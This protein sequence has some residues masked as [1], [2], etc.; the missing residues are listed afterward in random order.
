M[1]YVQRLIKLV[2][3][4]IAVPAPYFSTLVPGSRFQLSDLAAA[5]TTVEKNGDSKSDMLR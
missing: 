3:S 4:T 2:G 1:T 5:R